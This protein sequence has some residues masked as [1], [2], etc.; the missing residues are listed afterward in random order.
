MKTVPVRKICKEWSR[1]LQEN[2]GNEVSITNRGQVVAYL[3]VPARKKGQ[4]VKMPDFMARMKGNFGGRMLS[5]ADVAW[6]D[7][8]MKSPY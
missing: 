4:K 2:A 7:E 8:A 6:L 1:V 3:R 5:K